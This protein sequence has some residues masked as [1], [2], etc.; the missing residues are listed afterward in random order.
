[1]KKLLF[2]CAGCYFLFAGNNPSQAAVTT[3][4]DTRTSQDTTL[5]QAE[6][7]DRRYVELGKKQLAALASGNITGW[8]DAFADEAVFYWSGGD[9]LGGKPAIAKYWTERR[10]NVIDSLRFSMDIWLPMKV[11]K[12]QQGPD[13]PGIWLLGWYRVDVRYKNGK[14]LNFWVHTLQHF[15][16]NDKIDRMFQYIDRAPIEKALG[17]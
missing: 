3:P 14:K 5:P 12:P 6:F 17:R 10:A 7:A 13:I 4:Q 2:F 16:N 1:M 9:S 11:N 8:M 15:N